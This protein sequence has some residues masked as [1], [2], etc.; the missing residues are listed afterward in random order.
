MELLVVLNGTRL[1]G[2][3]VDGSRVQTIWAACGGC[4]KN[5]VVGVPVMFCSE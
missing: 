2:E 5:D 3:D 4:G 1:R